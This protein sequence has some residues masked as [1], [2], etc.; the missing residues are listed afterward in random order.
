MTT[1]PTPDALRV[2]SFSADTD[3]TVRCKAARG[4][5]LT[6]TP[7]RPVDLSALRSYLPNDQFASSALIFLV[8]DLH[9][10]LAEAERRIQRLQGGA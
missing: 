2:E 7:S 8:I 4:A 5:E 3:G 10:R 9:H 6:A 1:A